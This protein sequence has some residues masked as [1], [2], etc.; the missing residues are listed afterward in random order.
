MK[1][2]STFGYLQYPEAA[3]PTTTTLRIDSL[4]SSSFVAPALGNQHVNKPVAQ[5][6]HGDCPK[7]PWVSRAQK[8]EAA[9]RVVPKCEKR[10]RSPAPRSPGSPLPGLGLP[11]YVTP[12][13]VLRRRLNAADPSR[14][15]ATRGPAGAELLV[16]SGLGAGRSAS[17]RPGEAAAAGAPEAARPPPA[18]GGAAAQPPLICRLRRPGRRGLPSSAPA[19]F[20][21]SSGQEPPKFA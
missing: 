6:E 2:E 16:R 5:R 15:R 18:W 14:A 11:I 10:G 7:V 20:P 13:E 21:L 12:Q 1:T 8:P 3:M 9:L 17:P 4:M 19:Q